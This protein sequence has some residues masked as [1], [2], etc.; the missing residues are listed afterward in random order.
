MLDGKAV[1]LRAE[2][3]YRVGEVES[4]ARGL[5]RNARTRRRACGAR[6]H[7]VRVDVARAVAV[8]AAVHLVGGEAQ[9]RRRQ[10]AV[11]REREVERRA[12]LLILVEPVV[13]VG[14]ALVDPRHDGILGAARLLDAVEHRA[15]VA[16][17]GDEDV[18]LALFRGV[19]GGDGDACRVVA[20]GSARDI[21]GVY[22]E[23]LG[24]AHLERIAVLGLEGYRDVGLRHRALGGVVGRDNDTLDE[25]LVLVGFLVLL[26]RAK[27]RQHGGCCRDYR[28]AAAQPGGKVVGCCVHKCVG[29]FL[30]YGL[31]AARR[32]P[33]ICFICLSVCLLPLRRRA[34]CASSPRHGGGTTPLCRTRRSG[35]S[36]PCTRTVRAG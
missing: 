10:E 9:Q 13:L 35:A 4:K 32:C 5:S 21:V 6:A 11:V 22:G 3:P 16:L 23:H 17:D 27:E 8:A 28:E 36:G 7:D 26:A 15:V 18:G 20:G 25:A 12:L 33:I 29:L 30:V 24:I 2:L 19:V 31:H 34:R 14:E 1:E